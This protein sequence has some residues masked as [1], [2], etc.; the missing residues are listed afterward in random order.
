MYNK[1][2]SPAT[3]TW[4]IKLL[5]V[6]KKTTSSFFYREVE[7][8]GIMLPK[9]FRIQLKNCPSDLWQRSRIMSEQS[10]AESGGCCSIF[11][12]VI[13][14]LTCP[15]AARPVAGA[16]SF[17]GTSQC[18]S[19]SV[20]KSL[21]LHI[22]QSVSQYSCIEIKYCKVCRSVFLYQCHRVITYGYGTVTKTE[23]ILMP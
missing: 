22:S 16:P 6:E 21:A 7:K 10:S 18:L 17:A 3:G 19:V 8:N 2:S 9:Q 20:A 13:W 14:A 23:S 12:N 11:A 5:R 1:F 4:F 15:D